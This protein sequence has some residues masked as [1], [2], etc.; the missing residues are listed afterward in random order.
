M[1]TLA[2]IADHL[3]L[4]VRSVSALKRSGII[5]AARRGAHDLGAA[6]VMYIR[7]LRETAAGRAALYGK[8]DLTAERAALARAQARKAERE[9]DQAEGRLIPTVEFHAMITSAFTRVRAKLLGL[10]TRLAASVAPAM[11]PAAAESI[12][13]D[14]VCETLTELAETRIVDG[15]PVDADP[16]DEAA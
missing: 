3:A 15:A 6:R 1:A 2:E 7:H 9:N 8:L 12:L 13:R 5:P 11:T 16:G 10:P 14:A 4:S